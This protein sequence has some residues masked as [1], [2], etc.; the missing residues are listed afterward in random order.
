M[1]Q[2]RMNGSCRARLHD[3][4]VDWS[5][6]VFSLAG[7]ILGSAASLAA[8]RHQDRLAQRRLQE[9][10]W[11]ARRAERK[12][13][14]LAFFQAV[15]DLEER[16]EGRELTGDPDDKQINELRGPVHRMW[17]AQK[18]LDIVS[19][20]GP[21]AASSGYAQALHEA[22]WDWPRLRPWHAHV[23]DARETMLSA[24]RG[25]LSFPEKW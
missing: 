4:L 19:D 1:V 3:G 12:D 9:E 18:V 7:V 15:Q 14:L 22:V 21:R 11:S 20:E 17:L 16:L 8:Q 10:H 13:A 23:R 25:D 6:G 24:A 2:R 5:S